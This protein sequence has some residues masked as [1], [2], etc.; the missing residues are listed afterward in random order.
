MLAGGTS[1]TL[2]STWPIWVLRLCC[3]ANTEPGEE[4]VKMVIVQAIVATM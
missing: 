2:L 3:V 1:L 4:H